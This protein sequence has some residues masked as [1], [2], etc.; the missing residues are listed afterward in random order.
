MLQLQ[1]I[2][3]VALAPIVA[4]F[5]YINKRDKHQREPVKELLKAFGLGILSIPVSLAISTPMQYLGF[6]PS[7]PSN[8]FD[9]VR[10]SFLGA[11]IP[12]EIAKFLMLWLLV[13][14]SRYFDEKM[15][16]IVYASI[17][18]LGFAA[19]EN[20]MY[21]VSNYEAWVSVGITRALFSVPGHFFFGVLMGYY[22]SMYRFYPV[23]R[24]RTG[25][26]V[27]GAPIL[28]HGL[29]DTVLFTQSVLPSL[30]L[31]LTIAFLILC[32]SL[33][34]LAVRNVK[35]HLER[36]KDTMG[37]EDLESDAQLGIINSVQSYRKTWPLKLTIIVGAVTLLPFTVLVLWG[38]ETM[39]F[40]IYLILIP[41]LIIYAFVTATRHVYKF[42]EKGL[43]KEKYFW[44]IRCKRERFLYTDFPDPSIKLG[45]NHTKRGVRYHTF[46]L[47]FSKFG[48]RYDFGT[49]KP[50]KG[51]DF[52][53]CC[54]HKLYTNIKG[55]DYNEA[56]IIRA[57]E[58]K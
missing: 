23:S 52:L 26:L 5:I 7:D 21:L 3:A 11:A 6:F 34:K 9:A 18:S 48:I 39:A 40:Y 22:Y 1:L 17:V 42:C 53:T 56:E 33:R 43:V 31:I 32:N 30:G 25:W 24:K 15:D 37:I 27:L 38:N 35:E 28:A 58:G 20:I 36:D 49:A 14:K 55:T 16:G 51:N 41:Y 10:I 57:S 50:D 19:V 54:A 46:S 47:D 45:Y 29:F 44:G 12:E 13:R 2:L 4:L 8:F